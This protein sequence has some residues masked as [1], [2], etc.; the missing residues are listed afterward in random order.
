MPD[1]ISSTSERV[2]LPATET[3]VWK[4]GDYTGLNINPKADPVR[5]SQA[6]EHGLKTGTPYPGPGSARTSSELKAMGV[7]G[8]YVDPALDQKGVAR[9]NAYILG[10][11]TDN[12][13][14][15]AMAQ[16]RDQARGFE[17]H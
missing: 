13:P 14:M 6:L 12:H 4:A 17:P 15:K 8:L 9:A 10:Q 3:P 5:Y 2:E 7:F 1:I 11:A 16:M